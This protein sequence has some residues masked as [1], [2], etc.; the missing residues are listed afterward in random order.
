MGQVY[1]AMAALPYLRQAGQGAFISV[2]SMEGR[3]ALPFQS[4]YSTSKHGLEGFLESLRVELQHEG[5]PISI[6]SIKPS[7]INT[8]FYNN[9]RTKLGVKPTGIPPYY[10][11]SLVADA[12]LYTA[13]HP[14]RDFIVGDVGR[15]LDVLQRLSLGL[16]IWRYR[17]LPS[18]YRKP[19]KLSLRMP[20]IIS[21]NLYRKT[22]ALKATLGIW[23]SPA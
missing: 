19:L 16:W 22:T 11:P 13:E 17:W 5:V 2:S 1:G 10:Q 18:P 23:S 4:A 14:V 6:T 21:M 12:I 7:V 15:V 8:P 20:Q 9:G 3:R